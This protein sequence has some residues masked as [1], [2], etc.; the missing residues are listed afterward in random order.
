M[1]FCEF[2]IMYDYSYDMSGITSQITGVSIVYSTVCSG[3]H[4]RKHQSSTSLAF[5]RRIQWWPVNSPLKGSVTRKY[6][7][8]MMSSCRNAVQFTLKITYDFETLPGGAK[9]VSKWLITGA[10]TFAEMIINTSAMKILET[11]SNKIIRFIRFKQ[12]H[13]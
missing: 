13:W 3:V 1:W 4:R 5:V 6:F 9:W 7:Y 8:L 2:G 10:P 11:V 12:I